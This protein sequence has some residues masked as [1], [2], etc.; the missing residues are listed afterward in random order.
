MNH[1]SLILAS[2]QTY[3]LPALAR[4]SDRPERG[5]H[6]VRMLTAAAIAA[7]TII[8]V[9]ALLKPVVLQV[10]YSKAFGEASRYLRWTLIGD[11]LK[12]SSW[13]L[14]IPMLAAA[15]LRVLLAADLAAYAVFAAGATLASEI[16]GAAEGTAIAFV[17]MYACH[18]VVCGSIAR[19][20]YGFHPGAGAVL[21]WAAG[22]ALVLAVSAMTWTVG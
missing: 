16:R 21:I 9:L 2:V 12:V 7:A 20:R 10:L 8:C 19:V 4:T 18:I 15:D 14:S 6:L 5:A 1:V 22:L 17:L 11:Y 3:C 13:V